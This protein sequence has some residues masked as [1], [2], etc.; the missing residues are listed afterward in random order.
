MGTKTSMEIQLSSGEMVTLPEREEFYRY[1][2]ACQAGM[3]D[4][5]E[6]TILREAN[7]L[8]VGCGGVGS[9][10]TAGLVR[11]GAES[12]ML[13]DDRDCDLA[14]LGR[15]AAGLRGLGRNRAIVAAELSHDVNPF[16]Q[17]ST[18]PAG[19]TP[20]TVEGLVNF[21]DIIIDA[22]GIETPDEFEARFL[23][24]QEAKRQRIPVISGFDIADSGWV[25]VYDYREARREV[26]DGA[27]TKLDLE[28]GLAQNPIPI[29][30]RMI[31]LSRAPVEMIREAERV[32]AGQRDELSRLASAANLA[33][34]LV[35]RVAIDLLLDRPIRH[36]IAVDLE[37]ATR[38][39][40][41]GLRRAGRK[42]IA[43]YSL[44]RKLRQRRREGRLGVFSPLD[45]EVFHELKPYMDEHIYEAG[46]VIV[47]QGDP[48][49]DFFVIL[50]GRVQI[51]HEEE[52]GS[53]IVVAELGPG[54]YFGEMALLSDSPRGASVVVSQRCRVL[55]LSRGAFE[56]Y[57]EESAPAASRVRE[58]ALTRQHEN[59]TTFLL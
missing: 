47:R 39:N 8:V 55:V 33:G 44:Q 45:D 41:V 16:A 23:L 50:E 9:N 59:Q 27:F 11:A 19:V 34:A 25:V 22:L 42:L 36:T 38:P 31:S 58:A 5:D 17:I 40:G 53:Y 2:T 37:E 6:Q 20:E 4:H 24:H 43:L 49:E 48:A 21:S 15:V 1:L 3:L 54:D 28:G 46:S 35:C 30:G 12:L 10:V 56:I 32:L 26:L 7:I 51:E 13:T 29:I 14:H 18:E 52:D 57:L